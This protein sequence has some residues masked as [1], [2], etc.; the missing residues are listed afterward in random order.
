MSAEKGQNFSEDYLEVR[1]KLRRLQ[2]KYGD[3]KLRRDE[4]QKEYCDA[5]VD[6]I[7]LK[8]DVHTL[9]STIEAVHK[10]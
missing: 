2:S 7:K 1:E 6:L 9:E 3:L 10:Q 4:A 8:S 5:Q